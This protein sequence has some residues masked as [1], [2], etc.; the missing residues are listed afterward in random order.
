[1]TSAEWLYDFNFK[2]FNTTNKL[3]NVIAKDAIIGFIIIP[4]LTKNPQA[5]GIIQTL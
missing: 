1:M 5:T 3:L 2:T 4:N